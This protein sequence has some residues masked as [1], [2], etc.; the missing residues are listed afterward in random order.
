MRMPGA[1]SRSTCWN[2]IHD[3]ESVLAHGWPSFEREAGR[4]LQ[5]LVRL[6][7]LFGQLRVME[8]SGLCETI[9]RDE[10]MD[11]RVV[12]CAQVPT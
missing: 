12:T 9:L 1:G 7:D 5:V 2:R 3:A 8:G 4:E 10:D 11:W 6:R